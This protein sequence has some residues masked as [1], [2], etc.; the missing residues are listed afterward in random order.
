MTNH[1]KCKEQRL[2]GIAQNILENLMNNNDMEPD[3]VEIVER[4]KLSSEELY[5]FGTPGEES[6]QLFKIKFKLSIGNEL[7]WFLEMAYPFENNPKYWLS[8]DKH[9][10]LTSQI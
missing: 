5:A 2:T 8:C 4:R 10:C 6:D 7:C 3:T 1:H 9:F